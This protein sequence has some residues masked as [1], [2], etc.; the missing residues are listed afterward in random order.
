[1]IPFARV[2]KYGN[3][4][5]EP[6]N[7]VVLKIGFDAAAVGSTSI[8]DLSKNPVLFNPVGAVNN[9]V[10]VDPTYGNVMEFNG[11]IYYNTPMIDKLRLSTRD[12]EMRIVYK[13][14]AS[15]ENILFSTGDY[16]S[17]GNIVAGFLVSFFNN[18]GS[19]VFCTNSQGSFT[20]CIFPY[21]VNTWRDLSIFWNH[22]SKVMNVYDNIDK[23]IIAS[24]IVPSAFGDGSSLS[25]GGSYSRGIYNDFIGLLKSLEIRIIE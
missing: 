7:G 6:D 19:Q 24:V 17:A 3:I 14:A 22:T 2:L 9:K 25:V 21:S 13:S 15:S 11:G 16:Y 18:T 20:R 4:A 23:G 8:L 12:F 5:P 10:V 1:M